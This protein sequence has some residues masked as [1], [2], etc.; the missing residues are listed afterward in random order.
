MKAIDFDS[1]GVTTMRLDAEY[2]L[3]NIA[4]TERAC[5]LVNQD[6]A[7]LQE[8]AFLIDRESKIKDVFEAIKAFVNFRY[9]KLEYDNTKDNNKEGADAAKY[10][11]HI[12]LSHCEKRDLLKIRRI[13]PHFLGS[14]L[15]WSTDYYFP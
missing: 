8:A 14:G 15:G 5:H 12:L 11:R 2:N 1:T 4:L 6:L 9:T 10:A 13:T 7:D 3:M